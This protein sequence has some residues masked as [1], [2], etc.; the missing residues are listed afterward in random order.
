MQIR[1]AQPIAL[2]LLLLVALKCCAVAN[3]ADL[4]HPPRTLRVAAIQFRSSR[5]LADNVSRLTKQIR[6]AAT[7]GARVVVFPEC[8]LSG[9]FED[10]IT[11]LSSAELTGAQEQVTRACRDADIWAI[12]GTPYRVGYR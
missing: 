12:V 11:N 1:C 10:V 5:N 9:Y 4:A 7:N 8:A 3:A 6:D 2:L